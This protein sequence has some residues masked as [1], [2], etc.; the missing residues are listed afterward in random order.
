MSYL[1][2]AGRQQSGPHR[3][4]VAYP[5][6]GGQSTECADSEVNLTQEHS[7]PPRNVSSGQD[8]AF[9]ADA[10][11]EQSKY[12]IGVCHQADIKHFTQIAFYFLWKYNICNFQMMR[13]PLH[14]RFFLRKKMVLGYAKPPHISDVFL[15]QS[16]IY[17]LVSYLKAF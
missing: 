7:G 9:Q 11:N 10:E 17:F 1:S 16:N 15:L 8:I 6:Q 2:S 4:D 3:L 14:G 13:L 5:H 12:L